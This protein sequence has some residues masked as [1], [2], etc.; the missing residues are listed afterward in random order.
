MSR[1]RLARSGLAP[2]LPRSLRALILGSFPSEASLAAG[3]YYA[4]PQNWFWRVLEACG[5]APSATAP[6]RSRVRAV[7]ANGIGIWDLYGEVERKGSGDDQIRNAVPNDIAGLW[8]ERGPFL[9]LLNGRRRAEWRRYFKALPVEPIALPST[10]PR[11]LH[12]NTPS[13]QAAAIEE[14]REALERAATALTPR[15]KRGRGR[16]RAGAR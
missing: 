8:E 7:K 6:Y 14:W 15:G 5:V 16:A 3:Q 1:G 11:P 13:S 12:W 4:H 10:S 9:V 2:I